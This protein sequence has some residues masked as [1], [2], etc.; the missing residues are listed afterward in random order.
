MPEYPRALHQPPAGR[1]RWINENDSPHPLQY[2]A[3]GMRAYGRQPIPLSQHAGW[4]YQ[5]LSEGRAVLNGADTSTAVSAGTIAIIGPECPSGWSARHKDDRC[6]IL[7]WIW[8]NEPSAETI[9]PAKDGWKIL[10]L[11]PT[12]V[13]D[14]AALH[15]ETKIEIT[16]NDA[17]TSLVFQT[18]QNRLDILLF[19]RQAKAAPPTS[20]GKRVKY[21]LA[22]LENHPEELS[23]VSRLC[24]ALK[25]SPASLNRLFQQHLHQSVREVAYGI[26]M[27]MARDS[28]RR[29]K[30]SVKEL[31]LRLGY[32][33]TNDFSR[34]YTHHWGHP[35]SAEK[36]PD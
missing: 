3:W 25:I 10:K 20:A 16:Q 8:R 34:A 19:R 2:L 28:L 14:L 17:L 4:T 18:L 15:R 30:I 6:K 36:E 11:N 1:A 7:T 13:K 12:T 31:A 32:R 29:T 24:D 33:H 27:T 23:P 35:P 21:A 22:W 9:K 26:R 5:L